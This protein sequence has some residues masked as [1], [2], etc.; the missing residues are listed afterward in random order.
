MTAEGAMRLLEGEV[1]SVVELV[2]AG[3]GGM[4]Q[5]TLGLP[6]RPI[7]LPSVEAPPELQS[8]AVAYVRV[9]G[10]QE[11]TLADLDSVL[12]ALEKAGM[13]ALILDLRGNSGGLFEVAVE[14]ARRFLP[15]GTIVSTQHQD[16]SLNTTYYARSPA[17]FPRLPLVVL[18]DGETA[19]SAEVL[20]GALKEN[21][22]ARLVGQ[23]TYGKGCSQGFLRLPPQG[24]LKVQPE[25][26]GKATGGIRITVA[27]FLSPSGEP[28]SGRGVA[29]HVPVESVD[30]DGDLQLARARNEALRLLDKAR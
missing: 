3:P 18:V 15:K 10:F 19:S 30:S 14:V 2:V 5:R 4:N 12:A 24:L 16:P 27:R 28:Y 23:P 20:A 11:N 25:A 9:N 17:P 22:R 26:G 6:R 7:V 8:G 1:G 29:P 21:R 13:R